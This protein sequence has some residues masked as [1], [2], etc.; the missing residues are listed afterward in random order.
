MQ[1]KIVV[2]VHYDAWSHF[3][4]GRNS[5]EDTLLAGPSDIADRFRFLVSGTPA[6]LVG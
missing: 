3:R 2:P 1:P 4:E 6:D 5:I